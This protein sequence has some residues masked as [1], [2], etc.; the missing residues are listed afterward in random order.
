MFYQGSNKLVPLDIYNLL[1]PIAL[2]FWIMGD[3]LGNFWK[4][5]YLCTDSFSNYDIVRLMKVLLIRYN[6][7]SSLVT[8]LGKSRIYIP[9][10]ESNKISKLVV[11]YIHPTMLYK[12]LGNYP[13]NKKE[14]NNISPAYPQLTAYRV[15]ARYLL[16][17]TE[18]GQGG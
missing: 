8:V 7:N 13:L 5:L 2:T 6:I 17:V 11:G 10:T 1:T 12:L 15:G 18:W 16:T 3:G 4:G 14:I 9:S